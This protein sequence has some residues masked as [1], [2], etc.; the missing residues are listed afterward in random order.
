MVR[1]NRLRVASGALLVLVLVAAAGVAYASRAQHGAFAQSDAADADTKSIQ[2][3]PIDAF[4]TVS[5]SGASATEGGQ[6]VTLAQTQPEAIN[7]ETPGGQSLAV[8]SGIG[9]DGQSFSVTRTDVPD[10]QPRGRRSGP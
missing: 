3:L 8:P 6:Q 1:N 10:T 4:G 5:F 7:L 2:I 9:P